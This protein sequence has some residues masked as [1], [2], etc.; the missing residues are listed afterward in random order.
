MSRWPYLGQISINLRWTV[1]TRAWWHR[2]EPLGG[3]IACRSNNFA[4]SS[5]LWRRS[6]LLMTMM[7]FQKVKGKI[8]ENTGLQPQCNFY[9]VL[10]H[11]CLLGF[12]C[13]VKCVSNLQLS[14]IFVLVV[15]VVVSSFFALFIIFGVF[16]KGVLGSAIEIPSSSF[17]AKLGE[18]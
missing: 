14:S 10:C 18:R 16:A 7:S 9:F 4:T 3:Q 15:W 11:V 1:G 8:L 12:D 13:P 2:W 6:S 17:F 5:T